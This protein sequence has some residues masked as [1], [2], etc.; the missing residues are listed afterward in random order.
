V[1]IDYGLCGTKE[2]DFMN[3]INLIRLCELLE[4][5]ITI[6]FQNKHIKITIDFQNFEGNNSEL[7][8]E[9]ILNDE[10]I[11]KIYKEELKKFENT[12]ENEL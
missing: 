10:L 4:A 7:L 2:S 9:E 3:L 5:P 1:L 6:N 8:L 11:N 12:K